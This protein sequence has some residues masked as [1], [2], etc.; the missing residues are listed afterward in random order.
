M[1]YLDISS[2]DSSYLRESLETHEN[3][4]M[5]PQ[6]VPYWQK[7]KK[8][9]WKKNQ[10][11]WFIVLKLIKFDS[12]RL[13]SWSCYHCIITDDVLSG[14]ICR[15]ECHRKCRLYDEIVI[16][17]CTIWPWYINNN[18]NSTNK[19]PNDYAWF[20][21]FYVVWFCFWDLP[22]AWTVPRGTG[23][24]FIKLIFVCFYTRM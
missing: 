6:Q 21:F 11:F 5:S 19:I 10:L 22:S 24:S 12:V 23:S 18:I 2:I 9:L 3:N 16:L 1:T 17:H 14:S 8:N 13:F 7:E 4:K 20:S 15:M